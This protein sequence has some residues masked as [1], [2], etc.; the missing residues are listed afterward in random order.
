[1]LIFRLSTDVV[2]CSP[3]LFIRR[4]RRYIPPKP[5]HAASQGLSGPRSRPTTTHKMWLRR[6]RTRDLWVSS[7]KLW[8]LDHRGG[9][10]KQQNR[11]T[12]DYSQTLTSWPGCSST[13]MLFILFLVQ[14]TFRERRS[15]KE[16]VDDNRHNF[17]ST[18]VIQRRN[19][20]QLRTM[21]HRFA[22]ALEHF[23][24]NQPAIVWLLQQLPSGVDRT[25]SKYVDFIEI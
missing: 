9:Q 24:T 20:Q 18:A 2:P 10:I 14:C 21:Y 13:P 16:L 7:Q 22:A 17:Y 3:I 15:V 5:T 8:L 23:R 12:L 6:N 11:T 19:S 4:W 25:F 1:M